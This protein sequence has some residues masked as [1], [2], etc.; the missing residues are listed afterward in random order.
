MDNLAH[1]LR[2]G[3]AGEAEERE[4][5]RRRRPRAPPELPLPLLPDAEA[6]RLLADHTALL[7]TQHEELWGAGG[8]TLLYHKSPK[9]GIG[10]RTGSSAAAIRCSLER[11]VGSARL[12][13]PLSAGL[14]PLI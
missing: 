4:R 8:R 14:C 7:H 1:R 11:N 3:R 5:E 2:G 6:L 10:A 12:I 13:Q 9:A